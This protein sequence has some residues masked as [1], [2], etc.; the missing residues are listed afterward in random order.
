MPQTETQG[1]TKYKPQRASDHIASEIKKSITSKKFPEG[2]RLP[3]ERAL[4]E[5]FGVSRLTIRDALRLLEIQGLIVKKK[6]SAGGAFVQPA[7]KERIAD[8][9]MDMLQFDGISADHMNETRVVIEA[10]IVRCAIENATEE[11]LRRLKANTQQLKKTLSEDND[12]DTET[13]AGV[14]IEFHQLLA[15]ATHILPL[16][17]IQRSILE[18]GA[19]TLRHYRPPTEEYQHHYDSHRQII[20]AI[21]ERNVPLAQALVEKHIREWSVQ[22]VHFTQ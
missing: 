11:D 6:G 5:Q 16:I 8:T 22:L 13:V 15:E 2:E 14:I 7:S 17:I 3:S 12:A 20:D 18:W 19:K 1:F 9:I 4:A 10:G 21:K